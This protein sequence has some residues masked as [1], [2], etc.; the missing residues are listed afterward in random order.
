MM[1][2]VAANALTLLILGLVV[3]FGI[4]TW[5]QSQ[6][7]GRGAA[8]P[9][10]LDFQVERGEG[11]ASVADRLAEA[12]AISNASVFRIAARYAD[13][14]AGLRFGEYSIPAGASMREILEL[15]NRGGNVLRQ[16]VVPEGLTSWQ[17]VELLKAQEELSGEIAEVPAEGS[18]APAGYDFQRGDDA[19]GDPG[20]DGGA[21]A[22]GPGGGLGGAGGGP[23][24]AS[25]R[26][27]C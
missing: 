6:Y 25:R 21:A 15:L 20:A 13:L 22:G 27:S 12:G 14:D 1:R 18:L 5:V 4:V 26:R 19:H 16:V 23:A 24:A 11:L 9:A 3:L 8:R 7:R 2:H 10:P 17:V